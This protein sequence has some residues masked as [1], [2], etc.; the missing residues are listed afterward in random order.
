MTTD[1]AN[2]LFSLACLALLVLGMA[3]SFA[4][5]TGYRAHARRQ[6]ARRDEMRRA[7]RAARRTGSR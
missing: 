4:P 1:T 3:A 5:D 2:A 6:W 7:A